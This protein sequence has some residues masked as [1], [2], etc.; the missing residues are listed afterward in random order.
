VYRVCFGSNVRATRLYQSHLY[1]RWRV[2]ARVFFNVFD[3]SLDR[4]E[5]SIALGCWTL[6]VYS[7]ND[8]NSNEHQNQTSDCEAN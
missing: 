6:P 2:L 8:V 3:Q 4:K 1:V 7:P 5:S